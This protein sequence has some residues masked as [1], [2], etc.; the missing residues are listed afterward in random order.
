MPLEVLLPG[1]LEPARRHAVDVILGDFLGLTYR[2]EQ[3][4]GASIVEIRRGDRALTLSDAFFAGAQQAWRDPSSLP[5]LPL[6]RWD[7][8]SNLPGLP[9]VEPA[10]PVIY[11]RADAAGRYLTTHAEGLH[12]GLD[13]FGSAFFMLSR[14]EEALGDVER[15]AH[16]RFPGSASIACREGFLERPIVNEY[17]EL[18]WAC[19]TRLWPD[20]ERRRRRFSVRPTHDVDVP[21]SYRYRTAL[22]MVKSAG[23]QTF[24]RGGP[25]V[26]LGQLRDWVRVKRGDLERD[27][28]NCFDRIMDIS[29]RSGLRSLFYFIV[30]DTEGASEGHY[31]LAHPEIRDLLTRIHERGHEIG[32]H[33]SY[34]SH[35]RPEL[36]GREKRELLESCAGLG[37]EQPQWG[38]RQHYLRCATPDSFRIWDDAGLDHD[39]TYGFADGAGFRSGTCYDYPLYD[40]EAH[41]EL[42]IRERPLIVMEGTIID[43]HYMALG[44]GAEALARMRML[45]DRCRQFDGEFTLLWHNSRFVV[46]GELELYEALLDG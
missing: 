37:I 45:S 23:R 44:T 10:V 27:P 6:A 46:P 11:G 7:T 34:E 3:R 20:L 18:L 43:D 15:D 26:A 28:Y 16:G 14:Y 32:L 38:G 22:R 13:V 30:G 40:L 12:L 1:G 17:T 39:S 2:I 5:T 42:K 25:S 21:F 35:L 19:L 24:G 4:P 33:G 41:R 36:L 9:L 31:R 29:E 8:G